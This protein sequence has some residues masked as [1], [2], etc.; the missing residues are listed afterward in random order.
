L[1][2]KLL[3]AKAVMHVVVMCIASPTLP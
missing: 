3:A 1:S 2:R